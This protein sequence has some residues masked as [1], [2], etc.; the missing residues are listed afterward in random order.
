MRERQDSLALT[1]HTDGEVSMTPRLLWAGATL[2]FAGCVENQPAPFETTPEILCAELADA[3]CP[4]GLDDACVENHSNRQD[5]VPA[6]ESEWNELRRCYFVDLPADAE[7]ELAAA[8]FT[9]VLS[10]SCADESEA[11]CFC[12]RGTDCFIDT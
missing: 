11:L 8:P 2:L 6:C 4:Q 10:D 7:E 12:E 9:C 1:W 3:G 5:D